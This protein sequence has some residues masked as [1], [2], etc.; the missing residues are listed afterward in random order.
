VRSRKCKGGVRRCLPA[1]GND[2]ELLFESVESLSD[3]RK[4]NAVGEVFLLEPTSAE[5]EFDAA[6]T[7]GVDLGDT[8]REGPG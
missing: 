5:A 3:V 8:D 4:G 1:S 2:G 6:A 7:Q